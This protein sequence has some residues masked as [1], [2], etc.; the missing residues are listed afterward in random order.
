[1]VCNDIRCSYT[2]RVFKACT[3]IKAAIFDLQQRSSEEIRQAQ[4][5]MLAILKSILACIHVEQRL[6][7]ELSVARMGL[8][9]YMYCCCVLYAATSKSV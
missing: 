8:Y 7:L 6:I 4:F 1:M 3:S 5:C 9:M 2:C